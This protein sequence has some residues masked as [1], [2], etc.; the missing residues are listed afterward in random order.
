MAKLRDKRKARRNINGN[1]AARDAAQFVTG[2][3]PPPKVTFS[4]AAP[5]PPPP[6]VTIVPGSFGSVVSSR[7]R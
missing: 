5:T 2:R 3:I 6:T 1:V 7:P 4:A